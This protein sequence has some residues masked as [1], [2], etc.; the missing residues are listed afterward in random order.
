MLTKLSFSSPRFPLPHALLFATTALTITAAAACSSSGAR[1]AAPAEAAPAQ[2]EP[3]AAK[4]EAH[5]P[6]ACLAIS[7]ALELGGGEAKERRAALQQRFERGCDEDDKRCFALAWVIE[8]P[9]RAVLLYQ[10]S[11]DAGVAVAC[12]M[13]G[14]NAEAIAEQEEEAEHKETM[15]TAAFV[16][17]G[18]ACDGGFHDGCVSKAKMQY[19]GTSGARD[20]EGAKK[21]LQIPCKSGNEEACKIIPIIE[22]MQGMRLEG[23][24]EFATPTAAPAP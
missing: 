8:D 9:M 12:H 16:T 18:M 2:D 19:A 10:R 23:C 5:D 11:C 15:Y 17:F 6:L 21:T 1:T 22:C 3:I 13:F 14:L 7:K 4:C 24:P 20:L